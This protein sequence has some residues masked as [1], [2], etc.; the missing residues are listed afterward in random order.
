MSSSTLKETTTRYRV[1][2]PLGPLEMTAADAGNFPPDTRGALR[3]QPLFSFIP[4]FFLLRQ[5]SAIDGVIGAGNKRS[6]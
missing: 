2:F 1:A 3:H 5:V 4:V 6:F